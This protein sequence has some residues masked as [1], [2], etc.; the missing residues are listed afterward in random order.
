MPYYRLITFGCKVNQYDS[1]GLAQE[2]AA[3]GWSEAPAGV[4]PELILVNTCTVTA[5][6]DQEARQVIRRLGREFPGVPIWVTGCYA[7][8]AP[9][10]LASLPGVRGV[11]GNS[12]KLQI[13]AWLE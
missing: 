10:E 13:A 11:L 1:A 5:R 2:L 7:Q 12:E 9:G 3:R 4:R 6:A 8:R